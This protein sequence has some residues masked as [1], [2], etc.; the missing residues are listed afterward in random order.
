MKEFNLKES[1]KKGVRLCT[2]DRH[3]VTI[4]SYKNPNNTEEGYMFGKMPIVAMT[5]HLVK[6]YEG[7]YRYY[8]IADSFCLDGRRYVGSQF[9]SDIMI[10]TDDHD[11]MSYE[12]EIEI[13]DKISKM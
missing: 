11:I 10:V 7:T 8:W 1:K 12:E 5:R 2:R 4:V 13:A 9:D 6:N 3:L